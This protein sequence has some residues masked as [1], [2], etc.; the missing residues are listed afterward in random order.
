MEERTDYH[1]SS[2]DL[3]PRTVGIHT[4]SHIYKIKVFFLKRNRNRRVSLLRSVEPLK[5]G[6]L[7]SHPSQLEGCRGDGS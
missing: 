2:C 3:H 6:L 7:Q 4:Y 5:E 1:K